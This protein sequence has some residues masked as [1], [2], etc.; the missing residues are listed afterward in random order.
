[1]SFPKRAAMVF[2]VKIRTPASRLA[3]GSYNSRE[4]PRA[5]WHRTGEDYMRVKGGDM[6]CLRC[7]QPLCLPLFALLLAL[8]LACAPVSNEPRPP[9]ATSMQTPEATLTPLGARL[10][11]YLSGLAQS[12]DLRGSVLVARGDTVLLSRGYSVAD[13]ASGAPNTAT[14]RFRIGSI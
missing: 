2:H 9:T 3:G 5:N 13:E 1:M 4:H 6:P 8:L 10:D 11:A 14:T 12:G 7:F